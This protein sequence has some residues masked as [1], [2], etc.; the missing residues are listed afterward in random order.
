MMRIFP[1]VGLS[2]VLI[3][4]WLGVAFFHHPPISRYPASVGSVVPVSA[5]EPDPQIMACHDSEPF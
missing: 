5:I 3:M 2:A 1:I 4:T